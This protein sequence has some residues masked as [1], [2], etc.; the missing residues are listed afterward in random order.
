LIVRIRV[1]FVQDDSSRPAAPRAAGVWVVVREGD[2]PGE[3]TKPERKRNKE[4]RKNQKKKEEQGRKK[5]KEKREGE[6]KGGES[7]KTSSP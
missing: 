3:G 1:G 5:E 4:R 7:W 2:R 6:G